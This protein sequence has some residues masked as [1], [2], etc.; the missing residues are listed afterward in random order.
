MITIHPEERLSVLIHEHNDK[1]SDPEICSRTVWSCPSNGNIVESIKFEMML[2]ERLFSRSR[3]RA[4]SANIRTFSRSPRKLCKNFRIGCKN[5]SGKCIDRRTA[6][7]CCFT[8][9]DCCLLID[10]AVH[11]C[12]GGS[13]KSR[14]TPRYNIQQTSRCRRFNNGAPRL[15]SRLRL[16]YL[17]TDNRK[18]CFFLSVIRP[19][20]SVNREVTTAGTRGGPSR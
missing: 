5:K 16:Q 17:Q 11:G 10:D 9:S 7:R 18:I 4:K 1:L 19:M 14:L 6:R 8:S 13:E 2:A 12:R 15:A 3:L 20:Y